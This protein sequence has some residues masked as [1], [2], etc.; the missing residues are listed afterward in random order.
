MGAIG[1]FVKL[2]YLT[3]NL[4]W[5]QLELSW[6]WSTWSEIWYG[7]YWNF[8][9]TQVLE[10]KFNI[11][12]ISIIS[13]WR[14]IFFNYELNIWKRGIKFRSRNHQNVNNPAGIYLLKV[15]NRNTRTRCEMCSKLTIKTLERRYWRR[16]GVFIGNF[17]RISHLVP[18]FLML[19]LSR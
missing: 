6:N 10:V 5:V 2:K 7:C 18:V 14:S 4:I 9:K 12:A 16:S 3:W 8:C 13:K 15:N 17:E 19:T 11:G 1:S